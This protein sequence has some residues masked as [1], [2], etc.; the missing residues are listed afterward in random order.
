MRTAFLAAAILFLPF[1]AAQLPAGE[2]PAAQLPGGGGSTS[3]G[4]AV[5]R[6][7]V[8]GRAAAPV[9]SQGQAERLPAV[10][11]LTPEERAAFER[12]L[13]ARRFREP[14]DSG[15]VARRTFLR[16]TYPGSGKTR[17]DFE[18]LTWKQAAGSTVSVEGIADGPALG[19]GY[20]PD[21]LIRNASIQVRFGH[22]DISRGWQDG[23]LVRL[24]GVLE[25]EVV[26]ERDPSLPAIQWEGPGLKYF[27]R[28][29]RCEVIER[30]ER[31]YMR[32]LST[33]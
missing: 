30:V 14:T 8:Q 33:R 23:K 12:E 21:L 17:E 1:P 20:G 10:R 2:R 24:V 25:R 32:I 28:P 6:S 5:P 4:R 9:A 26:P 15:C 19:K 27:I 7:A 11:I 18:D 31:P 29:L 22:D 13:M 16:E 3:Q